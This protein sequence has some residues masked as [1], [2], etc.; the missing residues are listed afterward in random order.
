MTLNYVSNIASQ[1]IPFHIMGITSGH[2]EKIYQMLHDARAD[3]DTIIGNAH[4][5]IPAPSIS[6]T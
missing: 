6:D 2:T 1:S 3:T 5:Q 4:F